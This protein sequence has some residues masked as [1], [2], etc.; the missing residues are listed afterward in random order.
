MEHE[1]GSFSGAFLEEE[2]INHSFKK[3]RKHSH[4]TVNYSPKTRQ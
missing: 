4:K 2:K 3:G 1:C